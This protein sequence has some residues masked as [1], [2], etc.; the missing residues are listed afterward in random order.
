VLLA[1]SFTDPNDAFDVCATLRVLGCLGNETVNP[2]AAKSLLL[3]TG[4]LRA[5]RVLK[6]LPE[7]TVFDDRISIAHASPNENSARYLRLQRRIF[8]A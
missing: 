8:W 2:E 6:P 3:R 5:G 7:V 1:R 4:E